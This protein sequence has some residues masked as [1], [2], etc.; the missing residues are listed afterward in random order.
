MCECVSVFGC[1][2]YGNCVTCVREKG[3]CVTCVC[4]CVSVFGFDLCN[5]CVSVF[6]CV[7]MSQCV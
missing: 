6:H 2:F 4:E 7:V 1:M 3:N 5:V